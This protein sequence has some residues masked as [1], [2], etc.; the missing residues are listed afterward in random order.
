MPEDS[1]SSVFSSDENEDAFGDDVP[2]AAGQGDNKD[3]GKRDRRSASRVQER[4]EDQDADNA[5]SSNRGAN[6]D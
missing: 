6:E 4:G 3:E 5:N 2:Q 1:N